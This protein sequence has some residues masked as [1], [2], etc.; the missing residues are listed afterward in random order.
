MGQS[1][2]AAR[3]TS[4]GQITIFPGNHAQMHQTVMN[5]GQNAPKPLLQHCHHQMLY[6]CEG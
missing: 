5:H 2:S 4:D 1:D 6:S 3:W